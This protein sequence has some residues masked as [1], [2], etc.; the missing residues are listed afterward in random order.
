MGT[1]K[2]WKTRQ[3]GK[4]TRILTGT[5]KQWRSRKAG[6]QTRF[7]T[8]TVKQW[9]TWKSGKQTRIFMGTVK[10]W[11]S[12][13]A[14]KR[15]RI[16]I[17]KQKR[18]MVTS[19]DHHH[20]SLFPWAATASCLAAFLNTVGQTWVCVTGCEHVCAGC[21]SGVKVKDAAMDGSFKHNGVAV[22]CPMLL[23][24]ELCVLICTPVFVCIFLL[25]KFKKIYIVLKKSMYVWL[26][27]FLLLLIHSTLTYVY[28][29]IMHV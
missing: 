24:S 1:V 4:Q 26:L 5:V 28:I 15:T 7:L 20:P 11:K 10:Q 9:K 19:I 16:L 3:A 18:I 6:K 22:L 13:K 21:E 23:R 29:Y 12:R 25:F 27:L 2:Q 14:G 17:G 8:G